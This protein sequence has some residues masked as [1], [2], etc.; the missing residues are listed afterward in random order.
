MGHGPVAEFATAVH[1]IAIV[2]LFRLSIVFRS[3]RQEAGTG[4][5]NALSN[6][7]TSSFNSG[8]RALGFCCRAR[9]VF[10]VVFREPSHARQQW[11]VAVRRLV[12]RFADLLCVHMFQLQER[13]I[14]THQIAPS[15]CTNWEVPTALLN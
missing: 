1:K 4:K 12:L 10:L 7:T 6:S 14:E 3:I 9:R 15:C 5:S 2:S 13:A 11:Q 8:R